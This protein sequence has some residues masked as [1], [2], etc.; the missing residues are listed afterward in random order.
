MAPFSHPASPAAKSA[1]HL[2]AQSPHLIP[3]LSST[4]QDLW[5][6]DLHEYLAEMLGPST[7]EQDG[8]VVW[9][10]NAYI[11]YVYRGFPGM[12]DIDISA[13]GPKGA[14]EAFRWDLGLTDHILT[15]NQYESAVGIGE[16][17]GRKV[18]VQIPRLTQEQRRNFVNA[19]CNGALFCDHHVRSLDLIPM[20]FLPLAFGGFDVRLPEGMRGLRRQRARI[21]WHKSRPKRPDL[22]AWWAR[23]N[24]LY[25]YPVGPEPL[26]P[27][28]PALPQK[29]EYPPRPEM[30]EVLHQPDPE[31]V[32]V[33][34]TDIEFGVA[35]R[36]RLP[37]YYE[38]I[39]LRNV[40]IEY[41]HAQ[42]VLAWEKVKKAIDKGHE[43]DLIAH[44]MAVGTWLADHGRAVW[45]HRKWE[46]QRALREAVLDGFHKGRLSDIAVIYEKM[47]EAL[48]NGVNGMPI[49]GSFRAICQED[50]ARLHP[51]IVREM[52]H[53]KNMEV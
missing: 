22:Q 29:P 6:A 51:A 13:R 38:G 47:S 30:T 1:V 32:A 31:L 2:H 7:G 21:H 27:V 50:W 15:R 44:G 24:L 43:Q 17:E 34:Q 4:L 23:K 39:R 11:V 12:V 3:N 35:P 25:W 53:R 48:P 41:H 5:R 14:L 10:M 45:K 18:K 49:F 36:E 20:V 33:I 26:L 52:E 42:A 8:W 46:R 40:A 19:Y 28:R 37:N 9:N 16:E